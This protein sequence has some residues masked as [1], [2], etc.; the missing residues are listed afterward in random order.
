LNAVD[1][2]NIECEA[3]VCARCIYYWNDKDDE[4]QEHLCTRQRRDSV[5]PVVGVI[6]S[7]PLLE[8]YDERAHDGECGPSGLRFIEHHERVREFFPERVNA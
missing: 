8:C 3:R 2:R 1:K 5:D 7:G 6:R 4:H